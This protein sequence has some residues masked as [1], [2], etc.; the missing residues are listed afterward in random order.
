MRKIVLVAQREYLAN[1][2]TKGFW[3][4]ILFFPVLLS[5][6]IVVPMLLERTK[7]AR[8]YAVVDRSGWLLEAADRAIAGGDMWEALG[9]SIERYRS[10]PEEFVQLPMVVQ[11]VTPLLAELE[12]SQVG[13]FARAVVAEDWSGEGTGLPPEALRTLADYGPAL[14]EW[15]STLPP[16][17]A[18]DMFSDVSANYYLRVDVADTSQAALNRL[19]SEGAIFAYFVIGEDPLTGSAGSKYVSNNLTDNDLRRWFG[20]RA[21]QAVQ[22]RRMTLE[23][24]DPQVARWIQEPITWEQLKLSDTGEEQQIEERDT[25]RQWAPVAFVYLLWISVWAVSQMLM[26]NTVEEKSNRV[27]EVLLSSV[28]SMELL[29]GKI[30][31]IATTG[32]TLVGSWLL[33]FFL[34]TKYIPQMLGAPPSLD[35]SALASD[36]ILI[37]SFLAYF[38]LGYLLYAAVLVSIGSVCNTVSD[39]QNMMPAVMLVLIIPLM[40]MMP[41]G[42]DP[43]GGLA[44]I[45]SFIPPFT[46]FVMMNRA[47]GP[48]QLW[49]YVATTLLLIVSILVAWWAG[50]KV[51]RI[52]ILLTGKP[53]KV[54]EILRW[55][56]APVGAVPE[57]KES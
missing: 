53:P 17:I 4:G 27:I 29:A 50:A 40:A 36:P 15:W 33:V 52:G 43:N 14:H 10:E 49:E 19:V 38:I 16:G 9:T 23:E 1:V 46:P 55:V 11:D 51:F 28:S 30:L 32:L 22:A 13:V 6:F 48:P 21:S 42:Q 39:A 34:G 7:G 56:R 35:L 41:I 5:A 24:I 12:P 47:A 20:R 54:R 3:F 8:Q 2:R 25:M 44:K 37:G 31:G 57:R 18:G 26:T 45:L